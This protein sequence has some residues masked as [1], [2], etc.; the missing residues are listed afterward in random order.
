MK[1]VGF[2]LLGVWLIAEG[3]RSIARLSF[4]YDTVIFGAL[5]LVAGVLIILRR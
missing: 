4:A 2:T 1:N 3:L 5:A